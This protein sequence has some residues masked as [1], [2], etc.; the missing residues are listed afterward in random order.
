MTAFIDGFLGEAIPGLAGGD[1]LTGNHGAKDG[2]RHRS[3]D[4]HNI[5]ATNTVGIVVVGIMVVST[6]G[7]TPRCGRVGC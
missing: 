3:G 6:S 7:A 5:T 4:H 1:R 2:R